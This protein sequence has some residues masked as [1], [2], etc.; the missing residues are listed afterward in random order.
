MLEIRE[1]RTAKEKRLFLNYALKLYKGNPYFVPP[2]YCDE[3]KLFGKE[4]EYCDQAESVFYLAFR[5]G[6]CVG[7]ISGI[8]QHA[9]NRKWEQKR[10]RFTRF[11]CEDDQEVA[12]ALFD[13]VENWGKEN[14]MEE[15][16]G[17]LGYSDFEREGLLTWGF[18]QLSTFEEQYNYDYYQKLIENYGFGKDVDWTEHRLR[19]PSP[20]TIA[21]MTKVSNAALERLG[22]KFGTAKN[23]REFLKKYADQFF[24]LV[25]ISY[26]HIYGSVPFTDR[27]KKVMI[28]NFKL[29]INIR[30]VA[31][32]VDEN[33]RA[34]CFGLCFPAIG[35]PLQ[36]SGGHLYPCTLIKLLHALHHPDC[37]D[38]A[39]VGV[40]PEYR[41]KGV[42]S[43]IF[44]RLAKMLADD[45]I[46][47][48]TNLTLVTN[49]NI[50]NQ[51]KSFESVEHKHRR[52]FVKKIGEKPDFSAQD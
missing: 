36:K 50:L 8:L 10:V 46:P 5:D 7:R 1:V 52:S 11:D 13:A 38:L 32:I 4:H 27:M 15:I 18:D 28:S 22:L 12:N 41:M 44:A 6:K 34:V 25:D 21:H 48:E 2:L 37:I 45:D 19:A 43:A 26:D 35:K 39:L 42:S 24:E 31:V 30:Y 29:I 17:P 33:D 51:W 16:V 9:S 47:A 14:G 3:K 40:R 49:H 23:T 20:E